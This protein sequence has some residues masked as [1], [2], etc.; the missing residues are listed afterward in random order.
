MSHV[1]PS[2]RRLAAAVTAVL[3]VTAGLIC[4]TGPAKAASPAPDSTT[5]LQVASEPV[6]P[7]PADQELVGVTASG[8]LVRD[9]SLSNKSWV[10]ASDGA[11]I[12]LGHDPVLSTGR[13]DLVAL[14]GADEI[15]VRDLATD[16]SVFTVPRPADDV[17]YAGAVGEAVFTT[18]RDVP[19]GSELWMHTADG[20]T[21][22]VAGLP[23][24]A[25]NYGVTNSS[26]TDALVRYTTGASDRHLGLMDVTTGTV[27]EPD[28][29]DA[30]AE[31]GDVALSPTHVAWVERDGGRTS[32]VVRARGTGETRR[33]PVGDASPSDYEIGLQGDYLTYGKKGGLTADTVDPLHALTAYNLKDGATAKL[34]DHVISAYASPSGALYVRGGTVAQGEGI[35]RVAPGPDGAAPTA[36]LVAS[37]GEPTELTLSRYNILPVIDLSYGT[38]A[39]M[40]WNLSRGNAEMKVT[41]RHDRTGKT[42][43]FT[44]GPRRS[45]RFS[46]AWTG[47]LDRGSLSAYNGDY[48]WEVSARPLNGIGP[49]L[50]RTGTFEVVRSRATPHDFN[51][52]GSPDLLAR[53][54]SGH[55]WREDSH[56]SSEGGLNRTGTGS[57]LVGGGWNVYDRIEAAANLGGARTGD[58]VARDESGV[59]WLYLGKGDGTFAGRSRIG[60][61]WNVYDKIAAGS[62][63]TADGKADLLA[64]DKSGVLWLYRGTGNWR[65]PFA[66]RTRVGGGWGI[67]DQ[68][69]AIGG[70]TSGHL[71]ARD[72]AGVLWL[73]RGMGDGTFATRTRVGGGWGAYRETVGIGD[74][75][76]DGRT[77]LFAYANGTRYFYAGTGD[78]HA[79]FAAR[80]VSTLFPA[81]KNITSVS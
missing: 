9:G 23:D 3:T 27:T 61:G 26:S 48:T 38:A 1:R 80:E 30:T 31:N 65:A 28:L 40:V 68:L 73:Y 66:S 25:R 34:L 58:L 50:T 70:A 69:T 43:E 46:I 55:L 81:G 78:W 45:W 76:Q 22:A 79:P 49:V 72:K 77:D 53:D 6:V 56:F 18:N 51:D 64:T 11:L 16:R 57:V 20:A 44:L 4:A 21:V 39:S 54:S 17:D 2:R 35:Y 42:A 8:Y 67:Y 32:V 47:D 75:N 62:D 59:L 15:E 29:W 7:F 5:T 63:I 41:L 71:V 37:T 14:L 33:V 36:T 52:N 12:K 19:A 24:G 13:G 10:R 74:A 60:G